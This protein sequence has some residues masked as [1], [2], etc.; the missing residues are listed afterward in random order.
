MRKLQDSDVDPFNPFNPLSTKLQ[1]FRFHCVSI[2]HFWA[3]L[4]SRP[5]LSAV[6]ERPR[7]NVSANL[8][9][10]C[11]FGLRAVSE[12]RSQERLSFRI[13]G[14]DLMKVQVGGVK[15]HETDGTCSVMPC[16]LG[17]RRK[18]PLTVPEP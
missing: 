8:S 5:H 9:Q 14:F 2:L 6:G 10:P 3:Q 16:H 11:R 7:L 13:D 1:A 4:S 17:S 18:R 12:S 15:H